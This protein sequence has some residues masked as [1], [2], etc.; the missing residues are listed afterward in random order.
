MN[1]LGKLVIGAAVTATVGVIVYVNRDSIKRVGIVFSTLDRVLR[2]KS[3]YQ[4]KRV[5]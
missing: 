2:G 3:K 4:A 5:A 1:M